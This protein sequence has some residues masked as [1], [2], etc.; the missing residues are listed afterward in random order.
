MYGLPPMMDRYGLGLSM[1]PGAMVWM[2]SCYFGYLLAICLHL[3]PHEM[4]FRYIDLFSHVPGGMDDNLS[5]Y[6]K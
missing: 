6:L 2:I 5:F 4:S 3:F 1:G